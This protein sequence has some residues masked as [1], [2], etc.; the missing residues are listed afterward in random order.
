MS[1]A[2]AGNRT[3]CAAEHR[4]EHH[5][6]HE[7]RNETG[8]SWR[9]PKSLGTLFSEYMATE[10]GA[11]VTRRS[12]TYD[13]GTIYF[14][15]EVPDD[16]YTYVETYYQEE[17]TPHE[18]VCQHLIDY[19][20]IYFEE[21]SNKEVT[22]NCSQTQIE[23]VDASWNVPGN[24]YLYITPSTASTNPYVGFELPKF[25]PGKYKILITMA[26]ETTVEN[27]EENAAHFRLSKFRINMYEPNE[28]DEYPSKGE[29][30][31]DAEGNQNFEAPADQT[32]TIELEYEF[33]S[34]HAI[35]QLQS[36]VTSKES[37]STHTRYL[38][39]AEIRLIP[40]TE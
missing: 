18:V 5:R 9:H 14:V 28:M 6:T 30:L 10:A 33:T 13:D 34:S 38:R 20:K 39:I 36:Y 12:E 4:T 1:D 40:V 21:G 24:N 8:L 2:D 35:L 22:K 37:A 23:D 31:S 3:V 25:V 19:M 17:N 32:S 29:N 16:F 7:G 11:S 15:D 26:P 27:N